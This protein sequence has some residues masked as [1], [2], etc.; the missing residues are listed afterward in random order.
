[1][2]RLQPRWPRGAL[3][4]AIATDLRVHVGLPPRDGMIA[5]VWRST[6]AGCRQRSALL[7][8]TAGHR[9]RSQE[10]NRTGV[11]SPWE[12]ARLASTIVLSDRAHTSE[13]RGTPT[14]LSRLSICR[15]VYRR[16]FENMNASRSATGHN[17]A[18]CISLRISPAEWRKPCDCLRQGQA[19]RGTVS[20][21]VVQG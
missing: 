1:M 2:A 12:P 19:L 7:T 9:P 17:P 14:R 10:C 20:A 3:Y 6:E 13:Q 8:R 16:V 21:G 18:S 5:R 15:Q 11:A 4:N